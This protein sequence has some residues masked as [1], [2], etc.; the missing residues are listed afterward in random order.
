MGRIRALDLYGVGRGEERGKSQELDELRELAWDLISRAGDDEELV[1]RAGQ[2][3]VQVAWA[4]RGS[5]GTR[6]EELFRRF[7]ELQEDLGRQLLPHNELP[8]AERINESGGDV[9]GGS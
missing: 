6:A 7:S 4:Q 5:G 9:V 1:L 3:L 2:L 8:P